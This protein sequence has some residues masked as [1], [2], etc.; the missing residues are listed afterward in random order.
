LDRTPEADVRHCRVC[1][2]DVQLCRTPAEFVAHGERGRCVAI[3]DDLAPGMHL[4]EP[5]PE[6]VLQD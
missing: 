4:G 2:R 1:D 6:V 5:S 3:P